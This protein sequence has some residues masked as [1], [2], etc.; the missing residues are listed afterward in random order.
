MNT[1]GCEFQKANFSEEIKVSYNRYP[2]FPRDL[3]INFLARQA[4]PA[5]NFPTMNTQ[6]E[7][8]KIPIWL[9]ILLA[10]VAYFIGKQLGFGAKKALGV[11]DK[12][13]IQE[14]QP[15]QAPKISNTQSIPLIPTTADPNAV[16]K[17]VDKVKEEMQ[18][19]LEQQQQNLPGQ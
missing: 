5:K 15:V 2:N 10:I 14:F 1:N 8:K 19:K 3:K 7:K 6:S 9:L 16:L 12:P 11:D 17:G 13:K 18:K 4:F